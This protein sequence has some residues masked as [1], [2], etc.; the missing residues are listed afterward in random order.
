MFTYVVLTKLTSQGLK[1]IKESPA[2]A[3]QAADG[4]RKLGG[5]LLGMYYLQGEYDMVSVVQW[6]NEEVAAAFG[7]A[8]ASQGHVTQQTLRAFSVEEMSEIVKKMP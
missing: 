6:P 2:R 8:L 4:I 7:L 5:T 3:Q 1:N